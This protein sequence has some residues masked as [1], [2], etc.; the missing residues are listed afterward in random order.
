MT[1]TVEELNFKLYLIVIDLNQIEMVTH[2]KGYHVRQHAIQVEG[3]IIAKVLGKCLPGLAG[4][5][6]QD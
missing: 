2:G 6:C 3:A 5:H 4:W 1:G